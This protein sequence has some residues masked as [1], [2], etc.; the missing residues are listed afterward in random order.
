VSCSSFA[1]KISPAMGAGGAGKGKGK[2]GTKSKRPADEQQHAREVNAVRASHGK[3]TKS[4]A[5]VSRSKARSQAYH[6]SLPRAVPAA[7]LGNPTVLPPAPP[8]APPRQPVLLTEGPGASQIGGEFLP[9]TQSAQAGGVSLREGPGGRGNQGEAPPRSSRAQASQRPPQAEDAAEAAPAS[10]AQAEFLPTRPKPGG[11]IQVQSEEVVSSDSSGARGESLPLSSK[12]RLQAIFAKA[13]APSLTPH[14]KAVLEEDEANTPWARR[15]KQ[16]SEAPQT[17]QGQ[18]VDSLRPRAHEGGGLPTLHGRRVI[19]GFARNNL[20]AL[21]R[22][23]GFEW[24]QGSPSG[25]LLEFLGKGQDRVAFTSQDL[26]LKLSEQPQQQE[27]TYA[28]LL[29]GIAA[30]VFWVEDVEV[31]LHDDKGGEQRL[32]MTLLCQTP[33]VKAADVMEQRGATFSFKFLCHVGCVLTWLW[34]QNLHL[35]DL[36]ESNM[37]METSS[38]AEPYPALRYFDLL[39]WRRQ[40]KP[41][42]KWHGYHK[43]AQKMCPMHANWIRTVCSEVTQDAPKV[44]RRLASEC[45][46]YVDRLNQAGVMVEGELSPRQIFLNRG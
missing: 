7:S 9:P 2:K 37:G 4:V 28:S 5:S 1:N 13:K 17:E 22:T 33:V 18:I 21:P 34:T 41:D 25:T 6:E 20:L 35:L 30:P 23:L 44:F 32:P 12:E 45:Q 46:G 43:L 14:D 15:V 39:S 40:A 29:P 10:S 11:P 19:Q 8:K 42:A 26:V 3:S 16:R 27:L 36:G 24:H 38:T 31:V